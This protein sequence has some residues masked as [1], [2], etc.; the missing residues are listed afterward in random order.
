M[1]DQARIL[2]TKA[3]MARRLMTAT[4]DAMALRELKTFAEECDAE[5][6]RLEA[7]DDP[8]PRRSRAGA[9]ARRD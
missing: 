6:D 1:T 5:I 7:D 4:T 9:E 2:K 8:E 3:E